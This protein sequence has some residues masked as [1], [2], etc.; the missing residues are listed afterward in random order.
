ME[1]RVV[2]D[3]IVDIRMTEPVVFNV[4]DGNERRTLRVIPGSFIRE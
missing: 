4:I 2:T 3:E 1:E